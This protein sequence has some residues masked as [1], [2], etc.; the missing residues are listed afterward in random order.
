MTENSVLDTTF[1]DPPILADE[2]DGLMFALDR[3]RAQFAWKC[4][5][6]DA[7]GLR[8][9]HPPSEMTLGGLLKHLAL[10]EDYRVAKHLTG[11]P[12][13]G[14]WNQADFDADPDWEWHSAV[15]DSPEELYALWRGAVERSR[16]TWTRALADGG[17][18]RPSKFT[19]ESGEHPNL[20]RVLIDTIEEYLR[21]TG[22]ADLL[23]EAVDGLVGEDPPQP[24]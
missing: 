6:L 14:R 2:V 12:M 8:K 11:G 16:A 20:R 4:G 23:R 10:I 17:L 7:A 9:R 22:H 5:A 21:H 24:K 19:T 15:N 1:R 3:V 18:D 13:A